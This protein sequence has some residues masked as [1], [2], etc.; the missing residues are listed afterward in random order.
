MYVVVRDC[1]GKHNKVFFWFKKYGHDHTFTTPIEIQGT[2]MSYD[3]IEK[4]HL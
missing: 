4:L 2:L 3:A 1:N